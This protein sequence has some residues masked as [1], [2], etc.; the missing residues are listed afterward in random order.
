MDQNVPEY[1]YASLPAN[2]G[3]MTPFYCSILL[4]AWGEVRR[5]HAM[6]PGAGWFERL[7]LQQRQGQLQQ[8]QLQ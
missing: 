2:S 6:A 3:I 5:R 8:G 7:G 1:F 4:V